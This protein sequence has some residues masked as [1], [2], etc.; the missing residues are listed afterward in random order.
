[1]VDAKL[2]ALSAVGMIGVM[3][4]VFQV[5]TAA[6]EA[7]E[8][9]STVT[10]DEACTIV[11]TIQYSETQSAKDTGL[12]EMAGSVVELCGTI[13]AEGATWDTA[14]L[15]TECNGADMT[16]EDMFQVY[17]QSQDLVNSYGEDEHSR[18][19]WIEHAHDL[20]CG[21]EGT[22]DTGSRRLLETHGG[23][24]F[25]KMMR[26]LPAED[27]VDEETGHVLS[28]DKNGRRL[29]TDVDGTIIHDHLE[30]GDKRFYDIES[31]KLLTRRRLSGEVDAEGRQLWGGAVKWVKKAVKTVVKFVV[32][33]VVAVI[34]AAANV[35]SQGDFCGQIKAFIQGVAAGLTECIVGWDDSMID[36]LLSWSLQPIKTWWAGVMTCVKTKLATDYRT[37]VFVRNEERGTSYGRSAYASL[38]TPTSKNNRGG[39]KGGI[40]IVNPTSCGA[41]RNDPAT[42]SP[43]C[44]TKNGGLNMNWN[45]TASGSTDPTMVTTTTRHSNCPSAWS[46][47]DRP[48][49]YCQRYWK[50]YCTWHWWVRWQ[51][52]NTCAKHLRRCREKTTTKT[53][54]GSTMGTNTCMS[55]NQFKTRKWAMKHLAHY[56]N[57]IATNINGK[58]ATAGKEYGEV[59][60]ASTWHEKHQVTWNYVV[61]KTE[62]T[63]PII[64][65]CSAQSG[66]DFDMILCDSG[67]E[68]AVDDS[69][70]NINTNDPRFGDQMTMLAWG[71]L[72]FH[73]TCGGGLG[74]PL[75]TGP[76]SFMFIY[77]LVELDLSHSSPGSWRAGDV[78]N[79]KKYTRD[80]LHKDMDLFFHTMDDYSNYPSPGLPRL[81]HNKYGEYTEDWMNNMH[82]LDDLAGSYMN[83]IPIF[84]KRAIGVCIPNCPGIANTF[85]LCDDYDNF[86][87][88]NLKSLLNDNVAGFGD[89]MSNYNAYPIGNNK[90]SYKFQGCMKLIEGAIRFANAFLV[91]SDTTGND[92]FL[93]GHDR[94]PL[95][96]TCDLQYHS[97][98][99]WRAS[100]TMRSFLEMTQIIR[101][102]G[103][104][105][106]KGGTFPYRGKQSH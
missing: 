82:R 31:R 62:Y 33:V 60:C 1:M 51:C 98:W 6:E 100:G 78:N 86:M 50:G 28:L 36:A 10:L 96:A 75:D 9:G 20:F 24:N 63:L 70:L 76:M 64:E 2:L 57:N 61:D 49:G 42:T 95:D 89:I 3:A 30:N 17:E 77:L 56:A 46:W 84:V 16:F 39:R 101:G 59:G 29:V 11:F 47:Y 45:P 92:L 27:H 83:V 81:A 48:G 44:T 25:I 8:D 22:I 26:H 19:E 35:F 21:G 97:R 69:T 13:R 104:S 80:K 40:R 37:G 105:G 68:E 65:P 54:F 7:S 23:V 14:V 102:G 43:T 103:K 52:R 99:H 106:K 12:E 34:C 88:G 67:H 91:Q 74:D 66:L 18:M 38:L 53:V 79:G 15:N 4:M 72:V 85:G 93:V 90:I 71:N 73:G 94:P 32:K 87:F 5:R 58:P 55:T 41:G